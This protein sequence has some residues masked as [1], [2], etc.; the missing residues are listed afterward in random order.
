M[1]H[2]FVNLLIRN[3][4]SSDLPDSQTSIYFYLTFYIK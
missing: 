4:A 1:H 2:R 3:T